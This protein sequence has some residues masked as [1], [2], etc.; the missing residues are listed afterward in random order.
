MK[1]KLTTLFFLSI[2][3]FAFGQDNIM[4]PYK[5]GNLYGFMD[6]LGNVLVQPKYDEVQ[7]MNFYYDTLISKPSALYTVKK[8]GE[9]KVIDQNDKVFFVPSESYDTVLSVQLLKDRFITKKGGKHGLIYKGKA[10]IPCIYEDILPHYNNS[11]LVRKE[12][13]TGMI[14]NKGTIKIPL[15][16]QDIE[17]AGFTDTSVVWIAKG[18]LAEEY[19]EDQ[20]T[21]FTDYGSSTKFS[22]Y[23]DELYEVGP[24]VEDREDKKLLDKSYDNTRRIYQLLGD[25]YYVEK[26]KKVGIYDLN[27]KKEIIQPTYDDIDFMYEDNDEILFKVTLNKKQGVINQNGKIYVPIIMDRINEP[28]SNM[29]ALIKENK[30]GV[31]VISTIY[32]YIEPI[33]DEIKPDNYIIANKSWTFFLFRAERNGM[34]FY[35]GENGKEYK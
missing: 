9:I 12:G 5:S 13:L 20:R 10:I 18:V 17:F 32:P 35:V 1:N 30:I 22:N 4:I 8:N 11:C 19:F 2:Q 7:D 26:N 6:T 25:M 33:Y 29:C 34:T 23:D 3:Y 31:F 21:E 16:Y 15:Q 27:T 14:D 24:R 28:F